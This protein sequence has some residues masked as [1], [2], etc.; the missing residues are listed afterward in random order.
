[1]NWSWSSSSGDCRYVRSPNQRSSAVCTARNERLL[2]VAVPRNSHE[3]ASRNLTCYTCAAAFLVVLVVCMV[4]FGARRGAASQDLD[5]A[6]ALGGSSIV[7]ASAT[8]RGGHQADSR[9]RALHH[10]DTAIEKSRRP[11]HAGS[12]SS[13]HQTLAAKTRR[14]PNLSE[15]RP[16]LKHPDPSSSER[17]VAVKTRSNSNSSEDRP[18]P[19]HPERSSGGDD[20]TRQPMTKPITTNTKTKDADTP[21]LTDETAHTTRFSST[22]ATAET[23]MSHGFEPSSALKS[24]VRLESLPG[25]PKAMSTT[26]E[27]EENMLPN[28]EIRVFNDVLTELFPVEPAYDAPSN[29]SWLNNGSE[30][31]QGAVPGIIKGIDLIAH[32]KSLKSKQLRLPRS[33]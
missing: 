11:V 29:P 8:G 22:I 10:P 19:R 27:S 33:K 7:P 15:D 26:T 18:P 2:L 17:T 12:N 9:G 4:M 24:G 30:S 1:M 32:T 23:Q 6:G 31:Q 25:R 3:N 13:D 20:S 28:G 5:G 14:D 21:S 16:P